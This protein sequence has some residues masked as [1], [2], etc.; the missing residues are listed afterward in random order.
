MTVASAPPSADAEGGRVASELAKMF[1]RVAP[2]NADPRAFG[3]AAIA[4]PP[5]KA[6]S[7]RRALS[8]VGGYAFP[9]G[10]PAGRRRLA[11][12]SARPPDGP[13]C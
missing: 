12:S 1:E 8:R 5:T 6:S 13:T 9:N 11:L 10:V 2:N 4:A 3:I 7:T